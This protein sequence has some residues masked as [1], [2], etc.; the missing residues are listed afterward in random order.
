M[1]TQIENLM[2][3]AARQRQ[4]F[5]SGHS[6]DEMLAENFSKAD[7]VNCLLT[8]SITEDQYDEQREQLKYIWSGEARDGREL[9]LVTR[10]TRFNGVFVITVFWATLMDYE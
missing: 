10:L 5:Y 8:G 4:V 9:M 7:V 3:H 1:Y 6:L 2:Q